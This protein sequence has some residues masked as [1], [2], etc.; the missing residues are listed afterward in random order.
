MSYK[1]VTHIV[2]NRNMINL[3]K[4]IDNGN[5]IYNHIFINRLRIL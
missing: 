2:S 3:G 5:D 1:F 4:F